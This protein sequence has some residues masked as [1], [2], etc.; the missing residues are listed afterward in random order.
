MYSRNSIYFLSGLFSLFKPFPYRRG[1]PNFL[2]VLI[3]LPDKLL[4]ERI[5]LH[6]GTATGG[7][8]PASLASYFGGEFSLQIFK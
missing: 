2:P 3:L 1:Y 6:D 7:Q 4:V 8:F 5:D